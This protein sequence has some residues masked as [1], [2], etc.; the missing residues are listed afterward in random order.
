MRDGDQAALHAGD[1]DAGL[2]Q[3]LRVIGGGL[4]LGDEPDDL[5][6]GD[7]GADRE[8]A[9]LVDDGGGVAVRVGAGGLHGGVKGEAVALL[10]EGDDGGDEVF[11]AIAA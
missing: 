8:A 1:G 2:L 6:G 11:G 7:A 9:D 10:G 4:E 5:A 3:Q